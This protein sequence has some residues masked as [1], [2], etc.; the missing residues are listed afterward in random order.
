MFVHL[1]MLAVV[2]AVWF[3][4]VGL[5]TDPGLISNSMN[6]LG[7]TASIKTTSTS[8]VSTEYKSVTLLFHQIF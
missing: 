7:R 1:S 3:R 2:Q 8:R 6:L 4:M 5:E